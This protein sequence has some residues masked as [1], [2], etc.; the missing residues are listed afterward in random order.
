MQWREI[1][2]IWSPAES[3]SESAPKRYAFSFDPKVK[4]GKQDSSYQLFP[5]V[6][7]AIELLISEQAGVDITIMNATFLLDHSLLLANFL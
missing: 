1:S 6:N 3:K 7:F 5:G 4:G 2:Q